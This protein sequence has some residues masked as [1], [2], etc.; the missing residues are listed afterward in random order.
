M[1]DANEELMAVLKT[2]NGPASLWHS[3]PAYPLMM[4]IVNSCLSCSWPVSP[5]TWNAVSIVTL[6][7]LLTVTK[8]RGDQQGETA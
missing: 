1:Q 6:P 4:M 5:Y 7:H 8:A 3:M 2:G